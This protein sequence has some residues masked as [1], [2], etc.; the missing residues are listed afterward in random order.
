MVYASAR[1]QLQPRYSHERPPADHLQRRC[2]VPVTPVGPSLESQA[3][4]RQTGPIFIRQL[5]QGLGDFGGDGV[6]IVPV[7]LD[8]VAGRQGIHVR[9][10]GPTDQGFLALDDLPPSVRNDR[11]CIGLTLRH[12]RPRE[13]QIDYNLGVSQARMIG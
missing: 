3:N 8:A 7:R 4:A 9:P 6:K 13:L 11:D 10:R 2:H 1:L 12:P 5:K